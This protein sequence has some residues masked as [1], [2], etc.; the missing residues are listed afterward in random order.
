MIHKIKKYKGLTLVE[1]MIAVVIGLIIMAG[2]MQIYLS[3][4]KTYRMTEGLS[5]LQENGRFA[6]HFL[7]QDI[8]MAGF[9][10]CKSRSSA[11]TTIASPGPGTE[12]Y[13]NAQAVSA[14]NDSDGNVDLDSDGT[15]DITGVLANT[16]VITVQ[17]AKSCGGQLTGNMTSANA[18]IQ[19]TWPNSC[20]LQQNDFF[21]ISDCESAD[22]AKVTNNPN[23]SG[24]VQTV[25]HGGNV[26]T[27]PPMLSKLYG[28]GAEIYTLESA[29]F[30]LANTTQGVPSL[31]RRNNSTGTTEEL[32]D[33]I[34][35]LQIVYGEDTD[36]SGVANRYVPAN[37]VSNMLDVVSVRFNLR[38]RSPDA[39]LT[40]QNTGDKR[41]RKSFN[42]TI[43]IRNH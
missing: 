18:N 23:Q 14:V 25:T 22:I 43:A 33:N 27:S 3:N 40:Q 36:G 4:K 41:L 16:D 34:D 26:N 30:Y 42:S 13:N 5:R 35:D 2:V 21:I 12:L 39:N 1:V 28:P 10:G 38:A 7:V 11:V 17:Y 29:T 32:V 20:N 19:I 6:T 9:Q 31:W 15:D 37:S 8:R 24:T